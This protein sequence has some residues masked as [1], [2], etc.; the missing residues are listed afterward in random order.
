MNIF[1]AIQHTYDGIE[2]A[3]FRGQTKLAYHMI[4][5]FQASSLLIP[6]LN[7]T[8]QTHQVKLSDLAFIAANYGP[9]PFTTL[10]VV[11]ASING[12]AFATQVP[13]V[14]VDGL[15]AFMREH[16][17]PACD[18]TICM[19]NAFNN[20]VYYAYYDHENTLITGSANGEQFLREIAQSFA[21]AQ[22][23]QFLGNAI[24][25][26]RAL[27]DEL[28]GNR[29][30]IPEMI[31]ATCSVQQIGLMGYEQW[32]RHEN[33]THQLMPH[34]LKTQQFAQSN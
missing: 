27:I 1:V 22:K 21:N 8:L 32:Q 16:K 6:T 23:I 17:D 2:F 30:V 34:Y 25:P 24:A 18:R 26:N 12:I 33:V 31:P 7:D 3:L 19:L 28:F 11:I 9:G 5:K 4:S 10:R 15:D 13:L 20:D 14:G 29:A